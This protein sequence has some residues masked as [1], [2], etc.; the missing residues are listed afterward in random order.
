MNL[1]IYILLSIILSEIL[2]PNLNTIYFTDVNGQQSRKG[3]LLQPIKKT[4]DEQRENLE[5][6]EKSG[7]AMKHL[8]QPIEKPSKD[9][10]KSDGDNKGKE[11]AGSDSRRKVAN[12]GSSLFNMVRATSPPPDPNRPK[13]KIQSGLL[14][15][16][17][18]EDN[19]KKQTEPPLKARP[20][21]RPKTNL[22]ATLESNTTPKPARTPTKLRPTRRPASLLS[23]NRVPRLTST[24]APNAKL[25]AENSSS[26]YTSILWGSSGNLR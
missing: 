24:H 6:S 8:L 1:E 25:Q 13:N 14:L 12:K 20:T 3:S 7:K 18:S 10:D 4:N 23:P 2:S 26:E 11:G 5:S 19:S 9:D 22:I 17:S 21:K 16:A 15:S